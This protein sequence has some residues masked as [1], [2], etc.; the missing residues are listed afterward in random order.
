[1]SALLNEDKFILIN[2]INTRGKPSFHSILILILGVIALFYAMLPNVDYGQDKYTKPA[3][4][5]HN[6]HYFNLSIPDQFCNET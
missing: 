4:V 2:L 6:D 3:T 1:M 5:V